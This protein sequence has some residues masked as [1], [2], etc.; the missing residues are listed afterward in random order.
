MKEFF[1]FLYR[2]VVERGWRFQSG[3]VMLFLG[4]VCLALPG[5]QRDV[6]T[7]GE[8]KSLLFARNGALFS[9]GGHVMWA[10]A[11]SAEGSPPPWM[12]ADMEQQ[13]IAERILWSQRTLPENCRAFDFDASGRNWRWCLF[14]Y[15][16][17]SADALGGGRL[18]VWAVPRWFIGLIGWSL[19]LSSAALLISSS[20]VKKTSRLPSSQISAVC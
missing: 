5:P 1:I 11:Y 4:A 10:S 18:I 15:G 9:T 19:V 16:N 2:F 12:P 8:L 14:G 6:V 17:L 20:R 3:M 13:W 7:V